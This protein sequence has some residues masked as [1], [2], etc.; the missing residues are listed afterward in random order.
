M[1]VKTAPPLV[2]VNG[3]KIDREAKT[4]D[5]LFL[6]ENGEPYAL[7]FHVHAI[8]AAIIALTGHRAELQSSLPDGEVLSNQA[9]KPV[10]FHIAM[11]PEG[12]IAW[13]MML[14]SGLELVIQIEPD[15]FD[16]LDA[17]FD[18]VRSLLKRS[19]Q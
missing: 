13:K 15:R 17:M 3:S 19:V 5:L 9:L 10:G 1:E 4:V 18:E 2:A 8:P 7:K 16:R 6:A 11:N 14:Q 12:Q